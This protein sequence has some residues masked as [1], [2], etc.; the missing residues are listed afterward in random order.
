MD[1]SILQD[2]TV[3]TGIVTF[4]ITHTQLI[5][6]SISEKRR[7][8]LLPLISLGLGVIATGLILIIPKEVLPLVAALVSGSAGSGGY[9]VTKDVL[10]AIG[11]TTKTEVLEPPVPSAPPISF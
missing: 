2:S 11:G 8:F 4:A 9:G 5:K 7:A 6:P 10:K 3:I 1:F